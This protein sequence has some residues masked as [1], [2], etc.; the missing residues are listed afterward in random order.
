[1]AVSLFMALIYLYSLFVDV[2]L[3]KFPY[4]YFGCMG[5]HHFHKGNNF[6]DFLFASQANKACPEYG[7]LLKER[8]CS[9]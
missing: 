9:L 6:W 3:G 4:D 1:M 7:L 5:S 8:I 2:M